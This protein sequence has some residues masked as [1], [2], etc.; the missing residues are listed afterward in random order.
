MNVNFNQDSVSKFLNN[1]FHRQRCQQENI[2]QNQRILLFINSLQNYFDLILKMLSNSDIMNIFKSKCYNYQNYN[3]DNI[4][5]FIKNILQ[6]PFYQHIDYLMDIY[7]DEEFLRLCPDVNVLNSNLFKYTLTLQQQQQQQQI[8]L[9]I[10]GLNPVSTIKILLD[11]LLTYVLQNITQNKKIYIDLLR[12][13][14]NLS[15]IIDNYN[16]P[17]MEF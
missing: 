14:I 7:L 11:T 2:K 17:L 3:V 1:E 15:K 5:N 13:I 8:L 16:H 6:R 9:T 12:V 4:D 10:T